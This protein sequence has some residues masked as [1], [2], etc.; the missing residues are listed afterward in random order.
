MVLSVLSSQS[1]VVGRRMMMSCSFGLVFAIFFPWPSHWPNKTNFDITHSLSMC[2]LL[3][4]FPRNGNRYQEYPSITYN[5]TVRRILCLW[6]TLLFIIRYGVLFSPALLGAA[7]S[8]YY[9]L[10]CQPIHTHFRSGAWGLDR[11]DVE[12]FQEL[13]NYNYFSIT[14]TRV[15]GIQSHV[16]PPPLL[17]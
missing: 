12:R 6:S 10:P 7:Q 5:F 15:D 3:I 2:C 4:N 14:K 11:G 9:Y 16:R 8:L 1:S 13:I 17:T